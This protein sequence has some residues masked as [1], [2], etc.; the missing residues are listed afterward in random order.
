MDSDSDR[1]ENRELVRVRT[2]RDELVA[3]V[4]ALEARLRQFESA[5]RPPSGVPRVEGRPGS[6]AGP[7]VPLPPEAAKQVFE[8]LPAL[9]S[10]L[11]ADAPLSA[12]R[13]TECFGALV[14]L[15]RMLDRTVLAQLAAL[16]KYNARIHEMAENLDKQ[17]LLDVDSILCK[18]FAPVTPKAVLLRNYCDLLLRWISAILVG[19]QGTI[20]DV[21]HRLSDALNWEKWTVPRGGFFKSEDSIYWAFYKEHVKPNLPLEFEEQVKRVCGDKIFE[22]YG[23]IRGRL[24]AGS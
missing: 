1:P 11:P 16:G 5:E 6:S 20:L 22:A 21:N 10:I 4:L 17:H 9:G 14:G 12:L 2:E 3:R 23:A 18:S 24:L 15:M 13:L 19:T 7:D 8:L